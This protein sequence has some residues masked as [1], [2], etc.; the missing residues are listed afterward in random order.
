MRFQFHIPEGFELTLKLAIVSLLAK[1][2]ALLSGNATLIDA[3]KDLWKAGVG[4]LALFVAIGLIN[5]L[6]LLT[7]LAVSW[8]RQRLAGRFLR[9]PSGAGARRF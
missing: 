9:G 7:P 2:L 8:G 3:T 4:F 1:P 6:V 5:L